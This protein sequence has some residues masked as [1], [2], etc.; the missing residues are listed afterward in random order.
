M[1]MHRPHR[2]LAALALAFALA[3]PGIDAA[4]A[5]LS[6]AESRQVVASGQAMPLSQALARA[7][8][9]GKPVNVALCGG[10]GGRWVYE[11]TVRERDGSL[12]THRIS[13]SY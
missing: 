10:N 2:R 13:A 9:T 11:V 8:I 6:A 4:A 3:L 5:C 12:Q 1:K 7:G